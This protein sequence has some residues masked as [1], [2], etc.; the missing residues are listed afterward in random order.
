MRID[1]FLKNSRIIKRR[2]VAKDACEGGRVSINGKVAKPGSE[3]KVG[4]VIAVSFGGKSVKAEV[5]KLSEHVT[6]ESA[7]E[8]YKRL[9]GG[10][11]V[12]G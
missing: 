12:I 4:D 1:K 7:L 6:K 11:D 2:E 10:G 9:D 8:M 3:V 5:L